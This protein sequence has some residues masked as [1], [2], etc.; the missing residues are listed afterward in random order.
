MA[1]NGTLV[2]LRIERGGAVMDFGDGYIAQEV[3]RE[4]EVSWRLDWQGRFIESSFWLTPIIQA[5]ESDRAAREQ[6]RLLEWSKQ[7][8]EEVIL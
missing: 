6:R 3:T 4:K 7:T 8:A 5:V 2:T 1:D